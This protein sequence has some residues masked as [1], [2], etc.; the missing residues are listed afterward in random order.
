[1]VGNRDEWPIRLKDR[2]GC[3]PRRRIS[4]CRG[5]QAST[6]EA[7]FNTVVHNLGEVVTPAQQ[8]AVIVAR[9]G[10]LLFRRQSNASA[11]DSINLRS[12][13]QFYYDISVV[14][15]YSLF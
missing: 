9:Q 13:G 2:V 3:R 12:G 15:G 6:V 8:L 4:E 1:M 7:P 11:L 5:A 14:C 10:L